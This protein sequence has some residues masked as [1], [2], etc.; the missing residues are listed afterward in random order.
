MVAHDLPD[1][2]V[3]DDDGAAA[4]VGRRRA[5]S[6]RGSTDLA[7]LH[8]G[9]NAARGIS[10]AAAI[11]AMVSEVTAS[12]K[13]PTAGVTSAG[14]GGDADH[15][16]GELAARAQQ[17]AGLDRRRPAA[18][19][20]A[21]RARTISTALMAIRPAT[22]GQQPA[23]LARQLA[24]VDGHADGEEEQ[25]EQQALERARSSSR[26]PCGT[27]SP[28]AAGRRRRRRAPSTAGEPGDHGGADD[29]EQGRRHEQLARA[30]SKPPG[31]T[32]AAAA[33]ARRPR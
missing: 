22:A 2:A 16:E 32:A 3:A 19:G 15:D 30:V 8:A 6:E 9:R 13:L 7:F 23:R 4:A 20:T 12:V 29:D 21:G 33:A 1:A 26:S 17:Q 25:A 18:P 11:S 31:G 28:P 10:A 14:G 24:E 27:R 5:D